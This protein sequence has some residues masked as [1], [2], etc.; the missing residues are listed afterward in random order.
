MYDSIRREAL[1]VARARGVFDIAGYSST[2]GNGLLAKDT[3]I[4]QQC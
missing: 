2:K 4:H 1:L 3:H